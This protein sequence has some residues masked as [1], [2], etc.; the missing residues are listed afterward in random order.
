MSHGVIVYYLTTFIVFCGAAFG[1]GFLQPAS[2]QW[3]K[4]RPLWDCFANWDGDWYAKIAREGYQYDPGRLS[5][6]SF[7][8]AFPLLGRA[9]ADVTGIQMETALLI[10]AQ[11][12]LV[13][14]FVVLARYLRHRIDASNS[15]AAAWALLAFGVWPTAMFCRMAYSESLFLLS[16]VIS[17]YAMER[18]WPLVAI[19]LVIGFATATR[20]VG[21]CLLVPF[22]WHVWRES[23]PFWGL[24]RRLWL[25]PVACWGLLAFMSFQYWAFGEPLAF[26]QAQDNWRVR[27][28]A[29][30]TTRCLDLLLL[31]PVRAVFDPA[32]PCYW[33][34][35]AEERNPLFSLRLANPL[36]W[37]AALALV[38]IG[39]WK[40]WLTAYEWSLALALLLV[41]YLL[42]SHDMCMFGMGRFTAVAFPIYLVMGHLQ[43]RLPSTIAAMVMAISG[44]FL[45]AYA[46]LFV[47]WYRIF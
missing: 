37:L 7:F 5:N 16:A 26:A 18:R 34:R 11:L 14:T 21:V 4:Q 39:T 29:P 15:D 19:A 8:P 24:V 33:A 31:E 22:A 20:S 47:A 9:V 41:P 40:R 23:A 10:V 42:R 38:G 32:S 12:S 27:P 3:T 1:H 36:Y 28:A 43:A 45:A 6:I 30:A 13:A 2:H 35:P 17:L 44:F 46:A 25:L